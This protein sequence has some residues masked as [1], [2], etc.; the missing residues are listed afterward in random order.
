MKLVSLS[1]LSET[2][3]HAIWALIDMPQ[4]P[5]AA[6]VAWSFEGNGIRT[7]ATFIR[8]FRE[9][10]MQFTELPNLLKT[11]ERVI[12]LAG[13]LDPL[14]DLYVI[15]NADHERLDAFAKASSRPVINAMSASGH[16][17]EV[18][19]DAFYLNSRFSNLKDVQFIANSAKVKERRLWGCINKVMISGNDGSNSTV[20][21]ARCR[22]AASRHPTVR[23][24]VLVGEL[25]KREASKASKAIASKEYARLREACREHL[26]Q[27]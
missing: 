1:S 6:H 27:T 7:R 23:M 3:G 22:H 4:R 25:M 24:K 18:L 2:D 10:G 5:T 8:A 17:C 11:H 13:Y 16:P 26:L 9:L 15:R 19:N 14:F 20:M 12:D 21:L